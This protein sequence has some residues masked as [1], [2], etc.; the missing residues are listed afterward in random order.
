MSTGSSDSPLQPISALT[1]KNPCFI[2]DQLA[3]EHRCLTSEREDRVEADYTAAAETAEHLRRRGVATPEIGIFTGTGLEESIRSVRVSREFAYADLPHFPVAT[4]ESHPGRLLLGDIGGR[5]ALVMQGRVH[6]Y[7]GYSAKQVAFPVRVMQALGVRWMI[8]TNAAGGLNPHLCAGDIMILGDHI[9]L[10]G[11][12]P[13]VGPNDPRWG[14]RFPDMSRVYDP[15]LAELA[16]A[17]AGRLQISV[18]RGTYA[19]L[20]GPCLETPA[21][22]RFLKTIGHHGGHHCRGPAGGPAGGRIDP[23]GRGADRCLR[24]NGSWSPTGAC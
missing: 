11:E 10:T 13:L 19:G 7:E 8:V 1:R 23:H 9:N 15:R 17:C 24:L 5:P 22:V 16:E 20:K 14:V 2:Q 18:R 6:L 21:E 4:V 3:D 12:N